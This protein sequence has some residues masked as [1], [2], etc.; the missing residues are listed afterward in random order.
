MIAAIN[1]G[2]PV[3][4]HTYVLLPFL[5]GLERFDYAWKGQDPLSFLDIPFS[6]KERVVLVAK[7]SLLMLPLINS[8]I[9]VAMETFG[10][11]TLTEPYYPRSLSTK[12]PI[13]LN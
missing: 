4:L 8:I 3:W 13:R 1:P 11:P 5:E 6:L 9:W 2:N 12:S 10:E 7:G